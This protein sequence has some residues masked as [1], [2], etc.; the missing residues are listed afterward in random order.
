M[1]SCVLCLCSPLNSVSPF[2]ANE[3]TQQHQS[4]H[5]QNFSVR[6]CSTG[7]VGPWS[8]ICAAL[9]LIRQRVIFF[10][11]SLRQHCLRCSWI[12]DRFSRSP[13]RN[14]RKNVSLNEHQLAKETSSIC[15]RP[16][17]CAGSAM[18][19]LLSFLPLHNIHPPPHPHY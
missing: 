8:K 1:R 19:P 11:S 5:L 9:R 13:H 16:E 3:E 7:L 15:R 10:G 12:P 2:F 17:F 18:P 4:H 14:S 6:S